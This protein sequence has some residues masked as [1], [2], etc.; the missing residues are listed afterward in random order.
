[1]LALSFLSGSIGIA[2]S[3]AEILI[4]YYFVLSL[5][6]TTVI[7]SEGNEALGY[8]HRIT[9]LQKTKV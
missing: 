8:R 2:T 3:S 1:M 5:K 6:I 4:L 7:K 9:F